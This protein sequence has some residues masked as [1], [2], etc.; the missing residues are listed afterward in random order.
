MCS[1]FCCHIEHAPSLLKSLFLFL[2]YMEKSL[3]SRSLHYYKCAWMQLNFSISWIHVFEYNAGIIIISLNSA[4]LF[5]SLCCL[6]EP[7]YYMYC[8]D[9]CQT[10]A[11]RLVSSSFTSQGTVEVCYENIWGSICSISWDTNDAS[12]VCKQLGFKGRFE[13]TSL[14]PCW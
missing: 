12:V 14:I 9:T 8:L 10:G 7:W 3:F 1:H 4:W 2:A 6:L 11:V 13:L 5:I